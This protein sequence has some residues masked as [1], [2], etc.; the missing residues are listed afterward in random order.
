MADSTAPAEPRDQ[1]AERRGTIAEAIG[2]LVPRKPL[3]NDR[4]QGLVATVGTRPWFED[5]PEAHAV[6]HDADSWC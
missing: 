3:D 6:I 4:A 2:D 1:R 5:E